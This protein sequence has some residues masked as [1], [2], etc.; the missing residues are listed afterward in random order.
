MGL[1]QSKSNDHKSAETIE[2]T[3]ESR[4][5][6]H[7]DSCTMHAELDK[8]EHLRPN[9]SVKMELL[10]FGFIRPFINSISMEIDLNVYDI[11]KKYT[12]NVDMDTKILTLTEIKYIQSLFPDEYVI[13]FK[14][15]YRALR[16]GFDTKTFHKL[17]DKKGP[18]LCIFYSEHQHVFGGFTE[19]QWNNAN[20]NSHADVH[21]DGTGC[22]IET[23]LCLLRTPIQKD[24]DNLPI[25]WTLAP[26]WKYRSISNFFDHGPVF[27]WFDFQ[28]KQG[29]DAK[30][31]L[32]QYFDLGY[33]MAWPRDT[34]SLG[35]AEQF[36]II[37]YE[38]FELQFETIDKA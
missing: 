21:V 8:N 34:V 24:I 30:S 37:D 27:A 3:M 31:N 7:L 16:D 15:L 33:P 19:L 35:G 9:H 25:K 1:K 12:S 28:M 11:I 29:C 20:A 2:D 38:V 4:K 17:C 13:K 32:G 10:S 14:L 22:K 5:K 23:F 36:K 6:R 18:T 26:V